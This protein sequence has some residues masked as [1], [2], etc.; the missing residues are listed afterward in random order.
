MSAASGSDQVKQ[1]RGSKAAKQAQRK[2]ALEENKAVAVEILEVPADGMMIDELTELLATT[3]AQIIKTLF[4]KGIAVQMGQ[5]LDKDSV[6]AV[7]EDMEVEWIDE[8][9]QGVEKDAKKVTQ[10]QRVRRWHI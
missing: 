1:R 3:Q 10:F 6:I 4:M 7:A 9:E 5:Q 8:A 2:K